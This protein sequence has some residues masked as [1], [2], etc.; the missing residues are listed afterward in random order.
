MIETIDASPRRVRNFGLLL[1]AIGACLSAY[2]FAKGGAAWSWI[3]VASAVFALSGLYGRRA[4]RP[5]YMAWMM[6]ALLL[7]WINTRILLGVFF[8]LIV[9]P[10]G[11]VLRLTG[12]DLLDR[13]ID[14]N[15][16]SYWIRRER[17]PFDRSGYERLF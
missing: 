15:A 10:I 12:N 9:T 5:L 4:L 14:R 8:F 16:R 7:A 11:I 1:G 3:A 2:S 13:R 17:R 6:F